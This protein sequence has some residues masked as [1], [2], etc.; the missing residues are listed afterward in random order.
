MLRMICTVLLI[1]PS[2]ATAQ[3]TM[4]FWSSDGDAYLGILQDGG[5]VLVSKYPKA[6]FHGES[7]EDHTVI[8]QSAR[9]YFG[10][11]CEAKHSEYGQ[12]TWSWWNDNFTASFQGRRIS[13]GNQELFDH[14]LF[15]SCED[16]GGQKN[17]P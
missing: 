6:W 3:Q 4:E 15:A 8:E 16:H 5:A 12:G 17:Y 14:S 7:S 10:K 2:I 13:F 11:S 9:I 1:A